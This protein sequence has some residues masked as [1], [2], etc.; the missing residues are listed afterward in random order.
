MQCPAK[1]NRS[2]SIVGCKAG[3]NKL[4]IQQKLFVVLACHLPVLDG[5]DQHFQASVHFP[6]TIPVYKPQQHQNVF[7]MPIIEPGTA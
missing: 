4:W 1:K 7:G 2:F 5:C 3:T 6:E